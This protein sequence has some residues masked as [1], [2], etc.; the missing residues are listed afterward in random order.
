MTFR[1]AEPWSVRSDVEEMFRADSTLTAAAEAEATE[2][3]GWQRT[4]A[5]ERRDDIIIFDTSYR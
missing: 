4:T 2:R 3:W 1:E 5:L